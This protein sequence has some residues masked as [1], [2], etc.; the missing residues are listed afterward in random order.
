MWSAALEPIIE[1][2]Q[3][4]RLIQQI[5]KAFAGVVLGQGWGLREADARDDYMVSAQTLADCRAQDEHDDWRAL[6]PADL[7]QFSCALSFTNSEGMRFLLPAYLIAELRD[8]FRIADVLCCLTYS[9]L[10]ETKFCLLNIAQREAVIAFLRWALQAGYPQH[11][12][13]ILFQLTQG[14]WSTPHPLTD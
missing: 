10:L 1:E 13:K 9:E 7:D 11:R 6:S 12:S 2:L 8:E 5:E 3:L 4:N 14:Y